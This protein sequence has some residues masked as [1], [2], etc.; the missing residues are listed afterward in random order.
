MNEVQ[1]HPAVIAAMVAVAVVIVLLTGG[2]TVAVKLAPAWE[3]WVSRHERRFA[4]QVRIE[5]AAAIL[6]DARVETLIKQI[7]GLHQAIDDQR[8]EFASLMRTQREELTAQRDDEK[9]RGDRLERELGEMRRKLDD[10]ASQSGTKAG[11]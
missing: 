9:T 4:R 3:W 2:Q 7:E 1:T 8:E 10:L 11:A 6:N 5:A